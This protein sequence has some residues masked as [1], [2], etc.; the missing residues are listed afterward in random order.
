MNSNIA[1]LDQLKEMKKG[2]LGQGEGE[3]IPHELIE[4]CKEITLLLGEYQPL[5]YPTP[6]GTIQLEYDGIKS[7]DYLEFEVI[8]R[9]RIE[10]FEQHQDQHTTKTI[11]DI[12]DILPEVKKFYE[13]VKE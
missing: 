13:E 3:P 9:D 4:L 7:L 2:W 12:N 10:V 5:I 6:S 1:Y 8:S 11:T